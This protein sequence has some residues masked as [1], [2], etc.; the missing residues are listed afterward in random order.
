V[1]AQDSPRPG[2]QHRG[3]S[4]ALEGQRAGNKRQEVEDGGEGNE[5]EGRGVCAAG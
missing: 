1:S 5:G 2:C 4:F 3:D